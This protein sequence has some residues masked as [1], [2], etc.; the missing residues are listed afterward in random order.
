[1]LCK[2]CGINECEDTFGWCSECLDR[3]ATIR[4]CDAIKPERTFENTLQRKRKL[5]LENKTVKD[6]GDD[7]KLLYDQQSDE[8]KTW[9]LSQQEVEIILK[10]A[11][12]VS[13]RDHLLIR[14]LW[15][16]GCRISELLSVTPRDIDFSL[17]RITVSNL[18]M[19]ERA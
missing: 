12:T 4:A 10:A 5:E 19:M 13:V 7:S 9:V 14:L 3:F 8:N 2:N 18:N 16:T 17:R 6:N 11:R 1:M 15:I